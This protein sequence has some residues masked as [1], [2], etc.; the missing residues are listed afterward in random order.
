[1]ANNRKPGFYWVRYKEWIVAE[2][3][4]T[5]WTVTHNCANYDDNDWV[6]INECAL[7]EPLNEQS[8]CNIHSVSNQRELLVAL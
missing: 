5:N 7:A 1:M 4:G 8:N 3:D 2:W 6:E